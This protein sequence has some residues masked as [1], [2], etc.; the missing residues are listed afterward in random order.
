MGKLWRRGLYRAVVVVNL[1]IIQP[2]CIS[3]KWPLLETKA[4]KF[5]GLF[6]S[7]TD[8]TRSGITCIVFIC[9]TFYNP[10][11]YFLRR[12][13]PQCFYNNNFHWIWNRMFYWL[14]VYLWW[15]LVPFSSD[16]SFQWKYFARNSCCSFRTG[17]I[18]ST[19]PS[20]SDSTLICPLSPNNSDHHQF[21]PNDIHTL[22]RLEIKEIRLWELMK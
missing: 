11:F 16:W 5:I 8:I 12:F 19:L 15:R 21:S 17:K 2:C 13:I 4:L 3:T 1:V 7:G 10:I 6:A 14:L 9:C 18:P 22:K 20:I